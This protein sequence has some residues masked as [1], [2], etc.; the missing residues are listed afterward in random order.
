MGKIIEYGAEEMEYL[1]RRDSELGKHIARLGFVE[2]SAADDLFSGLCYSIINQQLSMKAADT[3]YEK[4]RA[5]VGE[6]APDKMQS[7]EK[8]F[9]CGLSRT[10][11][12]CLALC[13]AKFQSGELSGERLDAMTDDEVM[14]TLTALRGI[15]A[16]TAQMTMIFCL[17]RRDVLS[18]S[19]FG[20]RRGLSILHGIDMKDLA[21]MQK[22]KKLYSPYGTA[23]SIYL[24]EITK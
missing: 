9:G 22:Y 2:R 4:V 5:A 16:W 17:G 14:K 18:L 1:S 3:L 20:I 11:A 13:A 21:A 10:K 12:E 19:D 8:L 24:W 7:S 6:I 15:G 23:A